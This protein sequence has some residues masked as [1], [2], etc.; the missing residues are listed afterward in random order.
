VGTRVDGRVRVGAVEQ[1]DA[2]DEAR[3][4]LERRWV[5]GLLRGL[6]RPCMTIDVVRAL[7]S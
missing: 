5:Y 6:L 3:V 4:E 2:A 7:R 1:A